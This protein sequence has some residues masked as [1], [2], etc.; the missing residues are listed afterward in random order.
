MIKNGAKISLNS[1]SDYPLTK[2]YIIDLVFIDQSERNFPAVRLIGE[3]RL[4]GE[5]F[6]RKNFHLSAGPCCI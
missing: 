5:G 3:I 4:I 6:E 1:H 2:L